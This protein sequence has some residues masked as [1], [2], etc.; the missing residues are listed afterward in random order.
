MPGEEEAPPP[1]KSG[2]ACHHVLALFSQ[3]KPPVK[4]GLACEDAANRSFGRRFQILRP[5][6]KTRPEHDSAR[7]REIRSNRVMVIPELEAAED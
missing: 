4:A 7:Q 5:G 2:L 6:L 3:A 1:A